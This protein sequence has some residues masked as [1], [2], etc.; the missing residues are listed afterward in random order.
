[1]NLNKGIEY[2]ETEKLKEIYRVLIGGPEK[3][4]TSKERAE[5]NKKR[6]DEIWGFFLKEKNNILVFSHGNIIRYFLNK[7]LKKDEDLWK[8]LQIDS[9]SISIL[10]IT[11]KNVK[12]NKINLINHL[13]KE[14]L[15]GSIE[16]I[17]IE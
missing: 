16:K 4:G 5:E 15:K 17:Y 11:G 9:G 3:E 14:E 10:E 2:L 13:P 12:I 7:V 8:N 1:M 6:A